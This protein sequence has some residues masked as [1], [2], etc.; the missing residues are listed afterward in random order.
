MSRQLIFGKNKSCS[1]S[2]DC[3]K[4]SIEKPSKVLSKDFSSSGK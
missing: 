3:V 1:F 2:F 4:S